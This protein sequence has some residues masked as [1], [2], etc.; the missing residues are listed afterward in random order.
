MVR[1]L[2]MNSFEVIDKCMPILLLNDI[3]EVDGADEA[4]IKRANY[5]SYDRSSSTTITS[6]NEN[7]FVSDD[8]IDDLIND[9]YIIDIYVYF[10]CLHYAESCV[11]K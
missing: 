9:E 2:Y 4:Y 11:S 6:D 5:I 1:K 3:P 7:L 10:I 8:K